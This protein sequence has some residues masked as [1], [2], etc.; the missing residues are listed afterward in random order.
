MNSGLAIEAQSCLDTHLKRRRD[1]AG[2]K[3]RISVITSSGI[4]ISLSLLRVCLP[5]LSVLGYESFIY[6]K[7][8]INTFNLK[9][10]QP[11]WR[12]K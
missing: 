3:L 7:Q 9:K 5:F 6:T 10:P 2:M 8:N 1:F 12:R 4:H 11:N